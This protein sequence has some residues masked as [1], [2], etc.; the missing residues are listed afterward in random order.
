MLLLTEENMYDNPS[1]YEV[2]FNQLKLLVENCQGAH[3]ISFIV[4]DYT[5]N[6]KWLIITYKNLYPVLNELI[7]KIRFKKINNRLKK[8]YN[9]TPNQNVSRINILGE[10]L[11]CI[12]SDEIL[13]ERYSMIISQWNLNG[14]TPTTR[15]FKQA[16]RN[17]FPQL[18]LCKKKN[19]FKGNNYG[20][21]RTLQN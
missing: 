4:R 21:L 11:E 5:D 13:H 6:T 18:S 15:N 14:F 9:A 3:D 16:S 8:I 7:I 1:E 17:I 12:E 10:Y 20:I 2:N 19:S